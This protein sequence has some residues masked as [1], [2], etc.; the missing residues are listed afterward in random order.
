[1]ASKEKEPISLEDDSEYESEGHN[2]DGTD[3]SECEVEFN[4]EDMF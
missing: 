1:M 2:E 3:E 4:S